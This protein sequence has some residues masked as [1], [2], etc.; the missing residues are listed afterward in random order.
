[1][2]KVDAENALYSQIGFIVI[3]WGYCEQS[4]QLLVTTLFREYGGNTLP[5]RKRLPKQLGDKLAFVK[6]CA[7]GIPLLKPFHTEIESR[8][9]KFDDNPSH[10][11]PFFPQLHGKVLI[12]RA[13]WYWWQG[14]CVNGYN[15]AWPLVRRPMPIRLCRFHT[16]RH[17]PTSS[18]SH[19]AHA[20]RTPLA[21]LGRP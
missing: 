20:G 18:P 6:E 4:L 19:R 21:S 14:G 9:S 2:S 17:R 8:E 10:P 1:M 15:G 7:A 12:C 13:G 5:R 16:K 3:Q 11:L